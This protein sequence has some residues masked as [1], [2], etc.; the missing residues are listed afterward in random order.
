MNRRL[1]AAEQKMPMPETKSLWAELCNWMTV[2]ELKQM[3]SITKRA[4]AEVGNPSRPVSQ[5][6]RFIIPL[7]HGKGVRRGQHWTSPGA[8]AANRP[9]SNSYCRCACRRFLRPRFTRRAIEGAPTTDRKTQLLYLAIPCRQQL[10]VLPFMLIG[11]SIAR[12]LPL[13]YVPYQSL[14]GRKF[15]AGSICRSDEVMAQRMEVH[16]VIGS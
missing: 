5:G 4:P 11:P 15:H 14:A 1:Q 3:R 10:Q 9:T 16:A 13:Q 8:A 6:L 12:G 2:S 7:S